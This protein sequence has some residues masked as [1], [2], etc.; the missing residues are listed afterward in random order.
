[1]LQYF[2]EEQGVAKSKLVEKFSVR[3]CAKARGKIVE[4]FNEKLDQVVKV[5]L[6][7]LF[8]FSDLQ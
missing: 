8:S 3:L 6:Q 5:D 7:R 2:R 4:T 1:M